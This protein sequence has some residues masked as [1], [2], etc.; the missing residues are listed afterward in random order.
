MK[1][2]K[3]E[4]DKELRR[5]DVMRIQAKEQEKKMQEDRDKFNVEKELFAAE[6]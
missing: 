6:K 3:E 4:L 5:I 1:I 2:R